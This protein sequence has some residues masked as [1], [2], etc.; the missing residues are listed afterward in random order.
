MRMA[1]SELRER[2]PSRAKAG[3]PGKPGK[4]RPREIEVT[5]HE[6]TAPERWLRTLRLSG[7]T[8]I[9]CGLLVLAVVVLAPSLRTLVEQQQQ[10]AELQREV[11]AAQTDVD[12]AQAELDRWSDPAYIEAQ[13]RQRLM[14][15]YPGETSYM[16]TAANTA[17]KPQDA[18]VITKDIQSTRIDWLGGLLAATYQAGLTQAGADQLPGPDGT[19]GTDANGTGQ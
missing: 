9:L 16:V 3:R 17:K 1:R 5:A 13:A 14:F 19:S 6:E 15:V 7:F 12:S 10:I 11:D 2:V 18:P 8:V 4:G